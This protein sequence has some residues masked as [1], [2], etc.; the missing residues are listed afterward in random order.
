[1]RKSLPGSGIIAATLASFAFAGTALA[2]E[3]DFPSRPITIIIGGAAG[4]SSDVFARAVARHMEGTLSQTVLVDY[5]PGAGTNIGMDYVHRSEPDGYT[6]LLNGLPIVANHTLFPQMNFDP[7]TDFEPIAGVSKM[8]NVIAVHPSVPVNTL[9]EMVELSKKEPDRFVFG[10]PG[11]GTSSHIGG[12]IFASRTGAKITHVAYRGNAQAVSDLLGG[13]VQL[14]FVNTPVAA[15]FLKDGK[16]KALAVT[17]A[18]RSPMM[19]DVPTVSEALKLDN[20]DFN[21]WFGLLAPKGTP[22]PVIDKLEDAVLK[23]LADPEVQKIFEQAGAQTMPSNSKEFAVFIKEEQ[24]RIVPL[25]KQSMKK[26]QS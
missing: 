23:A 7:V 2:A 4:G 11:M 21:G 8:T 9:A 3:S 16:L 18:T 13:T 24:D 25:L 14:G 19:P 26:N 5:K 15:P 6:L 10:S 12:E 17:S 22:A 20:F 1:M